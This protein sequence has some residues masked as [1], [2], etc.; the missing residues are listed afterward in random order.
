[1]SSLWICLGLMNESS[2]VSRLLTWTAAGVN[3][4]QR[5]GVR[6]MQRVVVTYAVS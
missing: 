6:H 3:E 4:R 5:W 2:V 1:M